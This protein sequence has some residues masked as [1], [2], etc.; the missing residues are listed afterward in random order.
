MARPLS[1]LRILF[2]DLEVNYDELS[3]WL[4]C[5]NGT[6]SAAMN[7]K[8]PFSVW[9]M[10][11]IRDNILEITKGTDD[12]VDLSENFPYWFPH[13]DSMNNMREINRRRKAG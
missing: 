8:R 6:I 11:R 9:D 3:E 1:K 7:N 12:E 2:S 13:P 4:G 5:C 10:W